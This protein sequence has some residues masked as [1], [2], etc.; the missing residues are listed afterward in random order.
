MTTIR[1]HDTDHEQHAFEVVQRLGTYSENYVEP[2]P[3]TQSTINTAARRDPRNQ[4]GLPDQF[5]R[6][7]RIW[8]VCSQYPASDT[9]AAR[10]SVCTYV[11]KLRRKMG[12]SGE[13]PRY[14]FAE[15]RV[16]YRM[17][18]GEARGEP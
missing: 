7:H 15:P 4:D 2:T 16:G 9:R 18:K 5:R 10:G 1:A 12:D 11:K 6:E 13:D 8:L 17:E 14:I 3:P